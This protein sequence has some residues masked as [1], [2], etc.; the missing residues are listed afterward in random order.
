MNTDLFRIVYANLFS[1]HHLNRKI[2]HQQIGHLSGS[3]MNILSEF[4]NVCQFKFQGH[5]LTLSY[6]R[7]GKTQ[8]QH[9]STKTVVEI[10]MTRDPFVNAKLSGN[11]HRS[12]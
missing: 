11:L 8:R 3:K 6:H 1:S 4:S 9:D 2:Q 7:K 10:S 12:S 5:L